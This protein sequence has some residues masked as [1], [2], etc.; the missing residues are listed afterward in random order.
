MVTQN[1]VFFDS[2]AN[3]HR[4]MDAGATL[5][6]GSTLV[7]A[8]VGNTLQ[9]FSDGLYAGN[10]SGVVIYVDSV[11]GVDS[12]TAPNHSTKAAPFKTLDFALQYLTSLF[13][14]GYY[15]GKNC[16]IALKANQS[17]PM[18]ADFNI[19]TGSDIRITF[20]GDAN[21]GDFDGPAIGTGA[22][23]W[24]MANLA[25]PNIMPTS[26]QLPNGLVKLAGINIH[27]GSVSLLGVT[28]TLPAQPSN[29]ALSTYSGYS[30]F[31]RSAVTEIHTPIAEDGSI[32]LIG[33][34]VNMSDIGAFWGFLG[35]QPRTFLKFS[36]FCSQFQVGGVLLNST[37]MASVAQLNARQYFIKFMQDYP[38]NNQGVLS[39][40]TNSS[41][42]SAG[43][44]II[45]CS[46]S[47]AQALTVI[48]TTTNLP[49][50]P[51]SFDPGY[52]L[53]NYIFNLSRT[54]T[55]QNLN[56]LNSRLS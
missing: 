2:T 13:P 46:W 52:G 10:R 50:F 45:L 8:Q 54:A 7:S 14:E 6:V 22:N 43:S 41:N 51:L 34:I 15:A 18:T 24:N 38:G 55:N 40:A 1:P 4:P 27:G 44:G 12:A 28:I 33:S 19:V 26:S 23:P 17:Y 16:V 25:R 53:T 30:D 42:S 56:F 49:S 36:Q 5:P 11:L 37:S 9:T 35:C 29:P 47:E 39:L 31:V 48:G 20:Y 32:N 3:V 21:Y